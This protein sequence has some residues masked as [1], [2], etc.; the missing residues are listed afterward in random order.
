MATRGSAQC[1]VIATAL[2]ATSCATPVPLGSLAPGTSIQ[3]LPG[4]LPPPRLDV[5]D[6]A[7]ARATSAGAIGGATVG[8]LAGLACGPFFWIC[9]TVFGTGHALLGAAGGA[10]IGLANKLPA[11]VRAQL[12]SRAAGPEAALDPQ[13]CIL[14]ALDAEARSRWTVVPEGGASI[15]TVRVNDV[16]LRAYREQQVAMAMEVSATLFV[17]GRSHRREKAFGHIGTTADVRR[18]LDEPGFIARNLDEACRSL[19]SS[20]VAD[21]AHN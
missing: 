20:I 2:L 16:S 8:A 10:A 14:A 6:H 5:S 19:A 12:A 11:D 1:V 15:L 21:L 18:W 9:S 7:V 4:S 17:G 13:A 3:F